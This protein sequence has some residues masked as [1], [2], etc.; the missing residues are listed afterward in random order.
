MATQA[1]INSF[2]SM[3]A[4]IAQKA[5]K[6][7]GKPL[8]SVCIAMGAVE[9]AYGTAG[10]C[11]YNSYMGQKVGT[12]KTATKYW[13]GKSFNA[14]THEVVDQATGQLV[15]IKDNFRSYD[16]AEQCIMNYYELLNTSLYKKVLA[17]SGYKEQ[18]QQI[19]A[20]GYMTSITEVNSCISIISKYN[21]TQYDN[22]SAQVSAASN[23][24]ITVNQNP[25][26]EPTTNVKLGS[27]GEGV[28][29]AQWFLW[30]FGLINKSGID[31]IFGINTYAAVVEAQR[32]LGLV[33]DGII[34]PITRETW[35]N[36]I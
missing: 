25:F 1:Q 18:M 34:G 36:T 9:S 29:W 5:Y 35:K 24:K 27:R 3:I 31:G 7:F 11:K 30:R 15:T 6:Q 28:K 32:R 17:T 21:L 13:R 19:K 8:P 4:P 33:S 2:I 12:G 26:S 16:N 20:C 22:T 23:P 14:K 10:S